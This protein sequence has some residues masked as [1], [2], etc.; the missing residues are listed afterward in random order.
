MASTERAFDGAIN[1][2]YDLIYY[3]DQEASEEGLAKQDACLA[4]ILQEE[5]ARK[6]EKYD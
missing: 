2:G 3:A 6:K 5:E 4:E 1:M